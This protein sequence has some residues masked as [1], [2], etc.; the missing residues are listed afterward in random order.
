MTSRKRGCRLRYRA[1]NGKFCGNIGTL[2]FGGLRVGEEGEETFSSG[3]PEI[4]LLGGE[5][6]AEQGKNI[7]KIGSLL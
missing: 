2:D 1:L 6:K 5:A 4:A 3:I 7:R